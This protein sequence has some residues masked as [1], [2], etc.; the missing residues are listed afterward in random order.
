MSLPRHVADRSATTRP[1]GQKGDGHRDF[2]T[3]DIPRPRTKIIGRDDEVRLISELLIVGNVP[4]ITLTGPGGVGKT[5]LAQEIARALQSHFADGAVFVDLSRVQYSS[6]VLNAIALS[7]SVRK[8]GRGSVES[9]LWDVLR[10]QQ[11]LLVLD[12]FEHLLEAAPAIGELLGEC[13]VVQVLATSRA[14]LRIRGEQVVAIEPLS[15][16]DAG[17]NY[18]VAQIEATA[19]V[20]LLLER[21]QAAGARITSRHDNAE[22]IAEICRRLDG[23]PLAIEL[24]APRL[25]VLSPK[26][27]LEM[28]DK[29]FDLLITA[30]RD[31]PARHQ[32][33][34]SAIGWSYDL[35]SP[36]E[37]SAFRRL[38]VFV[39]GFDL[40]AAAAILGHD[41][42]MT[43]HRLERLVEQS[44]VQRTEGPGGDLRF[45]L[46]ETVR[47]FAA[48]RLRAAGEEFNSR[49]A[50]ARHFLEL[51]ESIEGVLYGPEMSRLLD[52]LEVEYAN[53]RAALGF[54]AKRGDSES[55]LRLGATLVEFW[56]HRGNVAEGIDLLTAAVRR[57]QS[58]SA[59]TRGRALC[60]L[61]ELYSH[62]AEPDA[63]LKYKL[64]SIEPSREE[65][66]PSRIAHALIT[67]AFILGYHHERWNEAIAK[68]EESLVY[69]PDD[70]P[71]G[72]LGEFLIEVGDI[73]R[74]E[75][76]VLR[77]LSFLETKG[78]RFRMGGLL[79]SLGRLQAG[80]GNANEAAALYAEA[81]RS[82]LTAG[83][84]SAF[85]YALMHLCVLVSSLGDSSTT[86]RLLGIVAELHRRF[87]IVPEHRALEGLKTAEARARQDLGARRF[88]EHFAAG[89]SLPIDL[90]MAET[91]AVADAIAASP[92]SDSARIAL[93]QLEKSTRVTDPAFD[94]TPREVEVLRLLAQRF[95]D[96][97]IANQ[98][99]IS[100][101]TVTTHTARIFDKLGVENR[102]DAGA[103]AARLGLIQARSQDDSANP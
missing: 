84:T 81:A 40:Q 17:A 7:L 2:A 26:A 71:L 76:L 97:E 20:A 12:N 72:V 94:L 6:G 75:A 78:N 69:L 47:E 56:Y 91:I 31:A 68:L 80:R 18:E 51:G 15:T 21:A 77:G 38:G 11:K 49:V 83:T 1:S 64:E 30:Q 100:Y 29:R 3:T 60:R 33:I 73:E 32:T 16:P 92:D 101:R 65:S 89:G 14:P 48:E 10:R 8:G 90:A 70:Y 57:G 37:Q 74:G 103:R 39:G 93:R 87:G 99:F 43:S 9:G 24:A 34:Q 95:T 58:A 55:E 28:L 27:L 66:Q 61:S 85:M 98:L 59:P 35:L 25:Q 41:L 46:L 82:F 86:A 52:Q 45:R 67:Y 4:L 79:T 5:R 13:P 42:A 50:H 102:R 96:A 62:A 88:G 44:L 23:L 22:T 53:M 63:A 36:E 54:F 19:A